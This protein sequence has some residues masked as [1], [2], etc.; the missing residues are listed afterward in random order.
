MNGDRVAV[1]LDIGDK[2][3]HDEEKDGKVTEEALIPPVYWMQ[4]IFLSTLLGFWYC[5]KWSCK[6]CPVSS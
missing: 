2:K 3:V 4:G 6:V 5:C 1:I